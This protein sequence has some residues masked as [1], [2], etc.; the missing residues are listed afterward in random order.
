MGIGMSRQ[1]DPSLWRVLMGFLVFCL[2]VGL[3][4]G[5]VAYGLVQEVFG[6]I[7]A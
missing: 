2:V 5:L 4:L 6:A 1:R 3:L 7:A